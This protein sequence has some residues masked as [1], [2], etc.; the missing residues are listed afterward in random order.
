M[1]LE[2]LNLIDEGKIG[3]ALRKIKR[4]QQFY[5]EVMKNLIFSECPSAETEW[6]LFSEQLKMIIE[7]AAASSARVFTDRAGSFITE[8]HQLAFQSEFQDN[9]LA[10]K[11]TMDSDGY[12]GCDDEEADEFRKQIVSN[13]F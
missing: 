8:F 6:E 2:L 5:D 13:L 7:S 12:G 4:S 9:F 10:K 3:I 1:D 11:F